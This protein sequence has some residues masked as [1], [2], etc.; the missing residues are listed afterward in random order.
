MTGSYIFKNLTS[1]NK[2]GLSILCFREGNY[3]LV[4][5]LLDTCFTS[6]EHPS[7]VSVSNENSYL[8]KVC[9]FLDVLLRYRH[10]TIQPIWP[11]VT[12][13]W[14]TSEIGSLY[15]SKVNSVKKKKG[16]WQVHSLDFSKLSHTMVW[17]I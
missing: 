5:L 17:G 7:K 1:F 15:I 4:F 10:E 8:I 12:R 2:L 3:T 14:L 16:K 11:I 6:T 13:I 9:S